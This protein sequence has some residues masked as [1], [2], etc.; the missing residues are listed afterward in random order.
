MKQNG[1]EIKYPRLAYTVTQAAEAVGVSRPTLYRWMSIDGFP[2]VRIGGT[3]RI[4]VD[5]F[6]E[7]LNERAD[8]R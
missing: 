3:V 6:R 5:A 8:G 4:P 1:T 7:W 2:A